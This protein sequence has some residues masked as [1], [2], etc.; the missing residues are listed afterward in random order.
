[1]RIEFGI[2]NSETILLCVATRGV[3]NN[4]VSG[5]DIDK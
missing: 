5:K 2:R 1:M 4:K 3:Y